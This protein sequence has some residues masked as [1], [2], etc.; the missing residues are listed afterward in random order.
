MADISFTQAAIGG[1][2]ALL[3]AFAG[4]AL[5][6]RSEYEKWHRQE[7]SN[8]FGEF[9][10]Q[11]HDTRITASDAY[12][13][14][15]GAELAKSIKATEAFVKLEKYSGIARLHMSPS[16]RESLAELT[17]KLWINCTIQGGPAN[18]VNEIKALMAAI[19][20]LLEQELAKVPGKLP[21]A[22]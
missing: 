6:R 16:G 2:F 20:T 15:E 3:G 14:G 18:R 10:R 1:L 19:Q 9:L 12:Y 21:W 22:L 4:A 13:S 8:A 17:K 5:T 11:L 7:K